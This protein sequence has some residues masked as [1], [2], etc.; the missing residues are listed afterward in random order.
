MAEPQ[1]IKNEPFADFPRQSYSI[2]NDD[3]CH[4]K[5]FTVKPTVK[6]TKSVLKLKEV[7]ASK[8]GKFSFT[9]E[10]KLWFNLPKSGSIYAKIKSGDYIKVHYDDGVTNISGRTFN[11]YSAV[12]FNRSLDLLALK[13]GVGHECE[14]VNTD[15]R[16]KVT[17]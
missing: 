9:D 17:L 6:T 15:N 10:T 14:K 8:N 7:V 16:L 12:N 2:I 5:L 4:E 13:V 11:L 1:S 3:F